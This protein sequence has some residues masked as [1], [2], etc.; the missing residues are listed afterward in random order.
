MAGSEGYTRQGG[1]EGGGSD[2][3]GEVS[4]TDRDVG[5][6]AM[7][8]PSAHRVETSAAKAAGE[9]SFFYG[10]DGE[11]ACAWR[12]PSDGTGG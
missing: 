1:S 10:W 12:Q 11:H 5:N 8:R 9:I 4:G 7:K 2:E 6:I 3:D